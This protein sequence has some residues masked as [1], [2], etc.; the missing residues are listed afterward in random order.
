[1]VEG[2]KVG[3]HCRGVKLIGCPYKFHHIT[4]QNVIGSPRIACLCSMRWGAGGI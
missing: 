3:L 1:M 2:V 4:E